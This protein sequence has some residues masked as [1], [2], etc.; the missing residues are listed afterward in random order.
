MRKIKTNQVFTP[1]KPS[2]LI[3]VERDRKVN[4]QLVDALNTPGKQIVIFGH[5]GCG[6]TTLVLNKL[7]QIYENY[8]ITRCM[9]GMTFENVILDGFDQLDSF[10]KESSSSKGLKINPKITL[11]YNELKSSI[12]LFEISKSKTENTKSVL[13]PQL[14]PQRLG[15]FF[16]ESNS[17]WV[18]EDFHKIVGENK[19]KIAQLMKV[20]MDMSV[21]YDELKIIAIG[22]VSTARQVVEYDNEL[23]G[24]V[25]E[26]KVP[27]M[28]DFE[29]EKIINKG[30]THLNIHFSKETKEKIIKYSCGSPTI[31][32]QICLNICFNELVYET[33]NQKVFFETTHLDLALE[34]YLEEKTDTLSAAF[35]KALKTS[36]GS[37]INLP[38]EIIKQALK[39]NKEFFSFDEIATSNLIKNNRNKSEK[40]IT[41]LCTLKRGE[42]LT[43]DV[44]SNK[45]RFNNLF[46]KNF[47]FLS[48][49][50]EKDDLTKSS[51]RKDIKIIERLLNIIENDINK[52]YDIYIEDL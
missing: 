35:D 48:F 24:R 4:N 26:I 38:K 28:K 22:A 16:G 34:K 15:N 8:V 9:R 30:E 32:H 21:N 45:Y 46:L 12:S 3:F 31:C 44:N 14:T 29:I 49:K 33:T 1:T 51:T 39:S 37:I 42:F 5:S 10:Y 6:K 40:I 36:N 27:I 19:T 13:P 52:D 25:S 11:Q 20:F 41:E 43:Y 47:A 18:L 50:D 7:N 2:T 17:C 23:T